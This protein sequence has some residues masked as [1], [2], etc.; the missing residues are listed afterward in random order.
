[1]TRIPIIIAGLILFFVGLPLVNR[2]VPMNKLYGYRVPQAYKSEKHW[3]EI[4]AYA[5]RQL[6]I[7][8]AVII[9]AGA[10]GFMVPREHLLKYDRVSVLLVV[11][12]VF[13]ALIRTGIWVRRNMP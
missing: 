10:A 9:L 6:C 11:V 4:N 1:M 7:W 12:P 3:Y 5:G 13:I 2:K 8:S